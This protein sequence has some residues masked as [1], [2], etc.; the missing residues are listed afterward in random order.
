MPIESETTCP[1]MSTS[2]HELIAVTLGF[3]LMIA[4]LLTYAMSNI[5]EIREDIINHSCMLFSKVHLTQKSFSNYD[6]G[7]V[8]SGSCLLL[9]RHIFF[10]LRF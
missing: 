5:T 2:M 1:V 9:L 3:L 8:I 6:I 7:F 4:G 10:Q